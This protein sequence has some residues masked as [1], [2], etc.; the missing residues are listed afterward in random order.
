MFSRFNQIFLAHVGEMEAAMYTIHIPHMNA[1]LKNFK[2]LFWEPAKHIASIRFIYSAH[3]YRILCVV[4]A[5]HYT[6]AW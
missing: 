6:R 1:S 4:S 5:R 3:L 2:E